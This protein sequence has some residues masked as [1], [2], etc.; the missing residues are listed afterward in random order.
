L[1]ADFLTDCLI[2]T[3][4]D[5]DWVAHD[6]NLVPLTP[7]K[8]LQSPLLDSSPFPCGESETAVFGYPSLTLAF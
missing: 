3:V 7:Q 2:A 6:G 5:V 1:F 4:V 8:G